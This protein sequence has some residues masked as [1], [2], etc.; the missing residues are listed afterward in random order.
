MVRA[1]Y[2]RDRCLATPPP[3]VL[4]TGY[5]EVPNGGTGSFPRRSGAG[6]TPL[7]ASSLVF[8]AKGATPLHQTWVID[9]ALRGA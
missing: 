4:D 2:R 6:V 7:G 1:A 9:L 3:G 5:E 8:F